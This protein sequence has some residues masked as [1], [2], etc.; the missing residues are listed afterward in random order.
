MQLQSM[1]LAEN[2]FNVSE[3]PGLFSREGRLGAQMMKGSPSM[4]GLSRKNK[5]ERACCAAGFSVDASTHSPTSF[6]HIWVFVKASWGMYH[7]GTCPHNDTTSYKNNP[8][9]SST[10]PFLSRWHHERLP[11]EAL[12]T[13]F[14]CRCCFC[15]ISLITS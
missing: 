6:S 13:S 12:A 11:W 15:V 14:L 4:L 1:W 9:H 7:C 3:S 5:T 10:L 2:Y 8:T